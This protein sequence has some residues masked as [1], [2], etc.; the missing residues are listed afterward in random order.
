MSK[1]ITG[2]I[3]LP[4]FDIRD[5][6]T[7]H[8]LMLFLH[9]NKI[10]DLSDWGV[11]LGQHLI[12]IYHKEKGWTWI[13]IYDTGKIEFDNHYGITEPFKEELINRLS[14]YYPMYK[15]AIEILETPE[16]AGYKKQLEYDKE[17]DKI[18]ISITE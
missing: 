2:V 7:I 8:E 9:R 18:L 15:K 13:K 12:Y 4:H 1:I 10:I 6:E 17:K 3:D 5:L 11:N 14:E 16:L